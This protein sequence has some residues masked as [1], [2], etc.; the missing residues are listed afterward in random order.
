MAN[1]EQSDKFE[2][3]SD[4]NPSPI[5]VEGG[6]LYVSATEWDRLCREQNTSPLVS[7]LSDMRGFLS[8]GRSVRLLMADDRIYLSAD[9]A[10]EFQR[11]LD[12][13]NRRRASFGLAPAI[14][15]N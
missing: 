7:V 3:L 12:D 5:Y 1:Q 11:I 2:G 8:R 4:G 10:S 13:A 6:N 9:G 14:P 15:L